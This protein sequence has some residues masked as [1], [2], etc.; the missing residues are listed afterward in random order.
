VGYWWHNFFPSTIRQVMEERL[1]MVPTNKQIGFF[2][3]AY[4]VEWSYAKARMV[5]NQMAIVLAQ[6]VG[7]GQY[8]RNDAVRIARALLFDSSRELLRVQPATATS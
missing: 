3:D 1:D 2:S 7:Q 8:T 6:K 4:C 5:L